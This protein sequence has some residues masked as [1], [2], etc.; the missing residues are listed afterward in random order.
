[1]IDN[2]KLYK[3]FVYLEQNFQG[4]PLTFEEFKEKMNTKDDVEKFFNIYGSDD[5]GE[6]T[7][8]SFEE[9][10]QS[11]LSDT[12]TPESSDETSDQ[13]STIDGTIFPLKEG[14]KGPEVAQL[15]NFLNEKIPNN[16]LTID[17]IFG[18]KTKEK[19]IQFQRQE[20]YV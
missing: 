5:L 18:T 3:L 8:A 15:Q 4:W 10:Y 1:M 19:L 6:F 17:G 20:G 16:P 7:A 9:F 11:L 2:N 13:I 14:S 12:P